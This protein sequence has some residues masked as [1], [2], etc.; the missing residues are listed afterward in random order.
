MSGGQ[1]SGCRFQIPD[2]RSQIADFGSQVAGG[3]RGPCFFGDVPV[4]SE[5]E[6][7]ITTETPHAAGK[8][9]S[10]FKWQRANGWSFEICDLISREFLGSAVRFPRL[11]YS[12]SALN[13][14]KSACATSAAAGGHPLSRG[15]AVILSPLHVALLGTS[16]CCYR[17]PRRFAHFHGFRVLLAA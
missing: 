11:G 7:R 1:G 9:N 3:W 14:G 17:T 12:I 4:R 5:T 8:R 15:G 13:T 6:D 16:S 10:K 2:F